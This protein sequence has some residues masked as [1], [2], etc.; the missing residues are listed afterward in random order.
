MSCKECIERM[1]PD[2]PRVKSGKYNLCG[3]DYCSYYMSDEYRIEKLEEAVK[4][5]EQPEWTGKQ[6]DT[7]QQ[8][9]GMVRH[10]DS[11]VTEMRATKKKGFIKYE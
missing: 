1:R 5:I 10:L 8:L 9:Q 7:V 3:C 6:W 11:K 2:D 4:P